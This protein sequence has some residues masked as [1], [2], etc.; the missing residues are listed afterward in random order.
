M[1]LDG[2]A[3]GGS[4]PEAL[5]EQSYTNAILH[6][7]SGEWIMAYRF[8]KDDIWKYSENHRMVSQRSWSNIDRWLILK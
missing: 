8:E 2:P 7:V 4:I 3:S 5:P 1:W 6:S